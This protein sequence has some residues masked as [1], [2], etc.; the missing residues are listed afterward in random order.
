MN[1]IRENSSGISVRIH[2]ELGV[3]VKA[4]GQDGGGLKGQNVV[5]D[6]PHLDLGKGLRS[7]VGLS[8]LVITGARF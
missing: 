3:A 2:P 8:A 4:D 5:T 1:V 6:V 7:V